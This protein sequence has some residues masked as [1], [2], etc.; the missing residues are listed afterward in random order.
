MVLRA[1]RDHDRAREAAD[2]A[3][4]APVVPEVRVDPALDLLDDRA[5][6][7]LA[8]TE[9]DDPDL[10]RETKAAI[11]AEA[12]PDRAP[13]LDKSCAGLKKLG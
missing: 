1:A 10:T 11:L 5:L 6:D 9:N 3:L 12:A 13:D 2:R 8:A 7:Q 4:E